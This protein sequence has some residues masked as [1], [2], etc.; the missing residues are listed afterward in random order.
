MKIWT[1]VAVF[2]CM[3]AG[4]ALGKNTPRHVAH[5]PAGIVIG[6]ALPS[7]R[8]KLLR[9]GWKPIEVHAN[10]EYEY[11][12]AELQLVAHGIREVDSCSSE[13][14]LHPVLRNRGRLPA[15][16]YDRRKSERHEGHSMGR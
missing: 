3:V 13:R 9:H 5:G 14:A 6:E 10:D 1:I 8:A 15:H 4:T 7:A 16:G 11:S 2:S 12:G